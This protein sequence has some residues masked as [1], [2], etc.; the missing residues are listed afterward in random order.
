MK[1]RTL[2]LKPLHP[3]TSAALVENW[4]LKITENST[5]SA[6]VVTNDLSATYQAENVCAELVELITKITS[7]REIESLSELYHD[8]I[9]KLKNVT[10]IAVAVND[11]GFCG[12][13]DFAMKYAHNPRTPRRRAVFLAWKHL[14]SEIKNRNHLTGRIDTFL[15]PSRD[16]FHELAE[17]FFGE[18][19]A[20]RTLDDDINKMNLTG[21]QKR[22]RG[23]PKKTG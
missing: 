10:Q 3:A 13:L 1:T 20:A 15:N 16:E 4:T 14:T 2:K 8:S 19:I 17:L 7:C 11:N 18:K 6:V 23:K 12:Q 22:P 9:R 5:A 21:I